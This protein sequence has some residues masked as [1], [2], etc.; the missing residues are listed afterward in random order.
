MKFK[1]MLKIWIVRDGEIGTAHGHR[2]GHRMVD[3]RPGIP[4]KV[5]HLDGRLNMRVLPS[6]GVCARVITVSG[7]ISSVDYGFGIACATINDAT[8]WIDREDLATLPKL[9]FS[10]PPRT[11]LRGWP[12][13]DG[14]M[15]RWQRD[16]WP[17]TY[18]PPTVTEVHEWIESL[19]ERDQRYRWLR[20]WALYGL[21]T[22]QATG[23]L[24]ERFPTITTDAIENARRCLR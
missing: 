14:I 11:V 17:I 22:Q 24:R 7:P 20:R 3:F 13:P 8:A 21:A 15:Q 2:D 16:S 12:V 23:V 18:P 9:I 10:I 19:S 5:T 1:Y 6:K 4:G